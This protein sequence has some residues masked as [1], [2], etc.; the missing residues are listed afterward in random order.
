MIVNGFE[1]YKELESRMNR[2]RFVL[3]PIF[4]DLYYH[5]VENQILCVGIMFED[6]AS[7]TVSITHDDAMNFELP[8]IPAGAYVPNV[9]SVPF[10][11][12][13]IASLAY[14]TNQ[15]LR[16]VSSVF[17][18]YINET[19]TIF[20]RLMD[21][22]KIIPITI[23]NDV[24]TTYNKYLWETVWSAENSDINALSYMNELLKVLKEIESAGLQIDL[25]QFSQNYDERIKRAFKT[26]KLYTEYNLLTTTG[27]PS[28]RFGGINF[29]AL[30][31]SD[32]TRDMFV[33]RYAGGKLVQIDFEA[34]HLRLIANELGIN[35]PTDK[36]IHT[37][38]AE[39][40]FDTT[41][42]S[43]E[44]YA[45]SKKRTFEIMYGMRE[46]TYGFEL[47]EKIKQLRSSYDGLDTIVLPS[48]IKVVVEAPS[49]NKLFNY[50]V[51][52]LEVVRTLPKLKD[53]LNL[54]RNT[55]NHLVLYTYD[56]IL[57][58]MERFDESLIKQIVSV[59]EENKKFPV[60]V[61][62][63]STYGSI[64]ELK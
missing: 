43:E 29:S 2:E 62:C 15:S 16:D 64:E 63:G 27:R 59:L 1:Q 18:Q 31:K 14:M 30:N 9:K 46:E 57:L 37:Q 53:V 13:D 60:R 23:W 32:G 4:R 7:Y 49:A 55:N 22:N 25:E 6:G 39:K 35:L 44:M 41:N 45:E 24:L 11:A 54:I 47:F 17:T 56:S 21:V 26:D 40:Y 19:H 58:D 20:G 28:N 36:S 42:I 5:V 8:A 61:Y 51:Q 10:D 50:Y 52:S 34:Y 33:S 38:M 12:T 3:T 48:G